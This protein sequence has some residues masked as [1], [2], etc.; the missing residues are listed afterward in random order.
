MTSP[1]QPRSTTTASSSN[2]PAH[3][4]TDPRSPRALMREAKI[5]CDS[6]DIPVTGARLRK[7]VRNYVIAETDNSFG[8]W[9]LSYADP[10]GDLA[11]RRVMAGSR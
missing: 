1:P 8:E 11:V 9:F 2:L 6:Y 10:T 5:V 3:G 4:E 7:L